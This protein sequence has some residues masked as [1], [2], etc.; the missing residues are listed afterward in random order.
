MRRSLK[1]KDACG[2]WK[3]RSI[4]VWCE[5]DNTPLPGNGS[6]E[7]MPA[8]MREQPNRLRQ[9]T[10]LEGIS[11]TEAGTGTAPN[12]ASTITPTTLK[13]DHRKAIFNTKF[14]GN[15]QQWLGSIHKVTV[16]IT[17]DDDERTIR[18]TGPTYYNFHVSASVTAPK[19]GMRQTGR[20]RR[21]DCR[22]R[23]WRTP[24]IIT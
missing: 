14:L 4:P 18:L 2:L 7:A 22:I 12:L 1:L 23:E 16:T 11:P 20:R 5:T 15:R 24:L 9:P 19:A 17:T 3:Q 8:P 21:S 13:A 6:I 10:R